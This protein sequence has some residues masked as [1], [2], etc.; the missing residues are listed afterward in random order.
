VAGDVLLGDDAGGRDAEE[1]LA[2]DGVARAEL[3][4]AVGANVAR[5]DQG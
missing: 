5:A 2:G 1:Q 4:R 3:L